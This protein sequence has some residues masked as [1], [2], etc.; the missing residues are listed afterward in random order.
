M[1]RLRLEAD[2]DSLRQLLGKSSTFDRRQK[3][4]VRRNI[5][6]AA[7]GSV[8]AVKAAALRP[9]Q[10]RG[11]QSRSTGLRAGIAS[12]TRVQILAGKRAGVTIVTRARLSRAWEARRGWRHPVYGD[13][14]TWAQQTGSPGYFAATIFARRNATRRAVENAMRD[15][16]REMGGNS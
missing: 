7:A 10:T 15:T 1:D 4:N 11:A 2:P 3:A 8:T 12:G 16:I 5:R 9:G 14:D 13:G 6:Q